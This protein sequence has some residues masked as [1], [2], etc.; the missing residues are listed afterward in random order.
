VSGGICSG[1]GDSQLEFGSAEYIG[2]G[3]LIAKHDFVE[4]HVHICDLIKTF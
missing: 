4:K 3:E 1:V 2:L